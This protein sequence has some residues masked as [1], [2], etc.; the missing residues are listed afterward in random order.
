MGN[1]AAAVTERGRVVVKRGGGDGG[2]G[3]GEREALWWESWRWWKS[4]WAVRVLVMEGETR[5]KTPGRLK[6]DAERS[7]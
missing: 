1:Q 6:E 2:G 7:H 4:S 3:G 5:S